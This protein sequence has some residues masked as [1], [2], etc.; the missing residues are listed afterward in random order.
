MDSGLQPKCVGLP[1]P[2][3]ALECFPHSL[4]LLS[5]GQG[6]FVGFAWLICIVFFVFFPMSCF[7]LHSDIVWVFCGKGQETQSTMISCFRTRSTKAG[8]Q[9]YTDF[10]RASSGQAHVKPRAVFL[11]RL[12]PQQ[13]A[14]IIQAG[15]NICTRNQLT[16]SLLY[17]PV[18]QDFQTCKGRWNKTNYH[19]YECMQHSCMYECIHF[20]YCMALYCIALCC[21]VLFR[22]FLSRRVLYC[23][24][25]TCIGRR[26]P[27][28]NL[29]WCGVM[30]VSVMSSNAMWKCN[31]GNVL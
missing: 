4:R 16:C 22:G 27:R 5:F 25:A 7:T 15:G 20:N 23:V 12:L 13:L 17:K 21:I 14:L 11:P 10:L 9:R 2:S 6:C 29:L 1:L 19:M 3:T 30:S 26:V 31:M 28:C 18:L 8:A 24:V